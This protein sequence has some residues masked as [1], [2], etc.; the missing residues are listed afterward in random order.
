MK[1]VEQ[2]ALLGLTGRDRGTAAA[3][4]Q[5]LGEL[6][7]TPGGQPPAAAAW[8]RTTGKSDTLEI[9]HLTPE[10]GAW[11]VLGT[12]PGLARSITIRLAARLKTALQIFEA[13]ARFDDRSLECT[14]EDRMIRPDGTS[15]LGG[16]SRELEASVGG[17]WKDLCDAKP[18]FAIGALIDA[19]IESWIPMPFEK[20]AV[21]WSPPPSLGDRRLDELALR[22]RMAVRAQLT[23]VDGRACVRVTTLDNSTTMSFLTPEELVLIESAVGNLMTR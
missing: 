18:Y 20:R 1:Q 17:K 6:G 12:S 9:V 14:I 7:F 2:A 11:A 4:D 21:A 22:I 8:P 15:A 13:T 19:A 16:F 10:R 23:T 3:L 5:V